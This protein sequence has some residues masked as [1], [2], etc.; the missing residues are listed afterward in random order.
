MFKLT[1]SR[2][3]LKPAS[4]EPEQRM[5]PLCDTGSYIYVYHPHHT[6]LTF[7]FNNMWQLNNNNNKSSTV[8]GNWSWTRKRKSMW[9]CSLKFSSIFYTTLTGK[10]VKPVFKLPPSWIC[11]LIFDPIKLKWV[12]LKYWALP[13]LF[14]ISHNLLGFFEGFC[15][16]FLAL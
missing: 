14:I 16:C 13:N 4:P 15:V 2:D 3:L 6:P 7:P 8:R 5:S 9:R 12:E 1:C 11:L 10:W